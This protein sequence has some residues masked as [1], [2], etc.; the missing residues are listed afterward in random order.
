M[1][2]AVA[3]PPTF[4]QAPPRRRR[5]PRFLVWLVLTPLGLA[6]GLEGYR[7]SLGGNFHSVVAGRVYRCAQPSGADL[8][9]MIA[10]YNIRTVI[11]LRGNGEPA[12]WY[13]EEARAT[14]TQ[15]VSQEDVC[16]SAGR[17]PSV[18]ELR[19][20]IEILEHT[21][22]PVVL[23]CRR[24]ADRTGLAAAIM[25]LLT[26]GTTLQAARW[27]LNMRFG[28]VALGRAAQLDQFLDFYEDWLRAE[29]K[30]HSA[31]LFRHWVL[32]IYCPGSCWC[33]LA[34]L[35][36]PPTGIA[37]HEPVPLRVRVRNSSILPWYLNPQ[38]TAG[39]HLGCHIFDDHDRQIDV[40]KTGL[41]DGQVLPGESIDLLVVLPL[42]MVDE[43]QCWFYQTGSE[44]LEAEVTVRE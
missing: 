1:T 15:N 33:E 35:S 19:R 22:Y 25:Q 4:A 31:E 26:P 27:Q 3:N 12:D 34:F 9:A 8:D 24:G 6:A 20:L 2:L 23:H 36:P 38:V 14:H 28:H 7:T 16:F 44:P 43:Q 11:N 40:V 41:R 42:D 39:T 32:N 5:F 21:E 10:Q 37:L 17:L 18:P 30:T 29:N 13:L